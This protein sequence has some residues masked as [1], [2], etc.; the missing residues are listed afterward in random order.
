M[1]SELE[2]IRIDFEP[3]PEA[4]FAKYIFEVRDALGLNSVRE[5]PGY[6]QLLALV[7]FHAF[8]Q[9][10]VE[11]AIYETHHGG[12]YCATNVIP[13]PVVTAV[14]TIGRD[15]IV[16]LGPS[17]ENIAWHKAGIFKRGASAFTIRQEPKVSAV[18]HHRATEKGVVLRTVPADPQLSTQF[19]SSVQQ[20]NCSLARA[21][22]DEFLQ[23]AAPTG[24]PQYL[25]SDEIKEG[26]RRFRWP[27][28]FETIQEDDCTWFL[29]VA[30]NEIS[31]LE[32][33]GWFQRA[34]LER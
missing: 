24:R 3:L 14:T 32:A 29:D 5:G 25:S 1:V 18:L 28:R 23:K 19:D 16:D 11:V 6:L 34:S 7:S 26:L 17:I 10:G 31:I 15:H 13:T 33:S 30:H 20:L 4:L 12:E 22:A 21:V 27:G 2:R 9:E 8:L